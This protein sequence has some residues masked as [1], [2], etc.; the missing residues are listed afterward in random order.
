MDESPRLSVG[1]Y[2]LP[3]E[4]SPHL[5]WEQKLENHLYSQKGHYIWDCVFLYEKLRNLKVHYSVRE[6]VV[7]QHLFDAVDP[8][9]E[10][11]PT[12]AYRMS[13]M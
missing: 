10:Y 4:P 12:A 5:G 1:L 11:I 13:T 8:L 6:T 7:H 3:V 9:H 2:H